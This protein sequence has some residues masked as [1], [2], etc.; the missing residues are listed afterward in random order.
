MASKTVTRSI[1]ISLPLLAGD[2]DDGDDEGDFPA[3]LAFT[4]HGCCI[5]FPGSFVLGEGRLD[6][7]SVSRCSTGLVVSFV[8]TGAVGVDEALKLESA[9]D[10]LSR[11]LLSSDWA[12]ESEKLAGVAELE[13][14]QLAPANCPSS[15]LFSSGSFAA[16]WLL[17]GVVDG[18]CCRPLP[19]PV[20]PL[21][22]DFRLLPFP[23][24]GEDIF[25]RQYALNLFSAFVITH[26]REPWGIRRNTFEAD[27]LE[28]S[29]HFRFL[30][31]FS[32]MTLSRARTSGGPFF[33][34]LRAFFVGARE[35]T[36]W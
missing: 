2:E 25:S 6:F 32:T 1:K 20:P 16:S 17:P 34:G 12:F 3:L 19:L 36:K 11:P 5:D 26:E 14:I 35:K 28:I 33:L 9:L 30:F 15:A 27:F 22:F 4:E 23:C 8:F 18:S 21:P 31:Y 29:S 13:L 7:C 24:P 10:R